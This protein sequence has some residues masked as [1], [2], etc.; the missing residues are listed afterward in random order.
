MRYY[1]GSLC[2]LNVIFC[3]I[4][5]KFPAGQLIWGKLKG[6]DWWPGMIV[7]LKSFSQMPEDQ[8][9]EVWV[10]WYGDNK[11]SKVHFVSCY[12]RLYDYVSNVYISKIGIIIVPNAIEPSYAN[13]FNAE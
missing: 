10:K 4:E 11:F 7:E 3:F 2:T 6:F 5:E 13:L 8:V 12:V 1:T 9:E